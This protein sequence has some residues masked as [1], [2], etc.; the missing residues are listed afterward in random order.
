[1]IALVVP[2]GAP[3]VD[4]AGPL[5]PTLDTNISPCLFTASEIT[6]QIRLKSAINNAP[7]DH[8]N[9]LVITNYNSR[10]CKQSIN[11][12]IKTHLYSSICH[13]H[14]RG[15]HMMAETRSSVHILRRQC[16]KQFSF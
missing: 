8:H 2:P 12:S 11:Q 10:Q 7:E 3:T 14:I 6:S 4:K 13:E 5:L 16:V 15:R 1:M 9:Q